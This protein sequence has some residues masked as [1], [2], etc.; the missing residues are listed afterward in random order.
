MIVPRESVK[1][2]DFDGLRIF[3]YTANRGLGSSL[4]V[5][6]VPIGGVHA[7]SW[8]KR[9]DKYYYVCEG[10]VRFVL[11]HEVHHLETGDF[12]FVRLGRHFS[13]A[14]EGTRAAKL[15]LVHSPSFRLEDE[16]FAVPAVAEV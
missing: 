11:D 8:S 4:A 2:F 16:E 5:I 9:S 15:V 10:A 3:D 6:E 13:Y 14:N 7:E 12:C 1:P